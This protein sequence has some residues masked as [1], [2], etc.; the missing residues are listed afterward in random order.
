MATSLRVQR[1]RLSRKLNNPDIARITFYTF[2]YW[3]G[4]TLYHQT[5]DL[6]KV[7]HELGHKKIE[8]T[9]FYVQIAESLYDDKPENY[10]VATAK[11]SEE[12]DKLLSE[13]WKYVAKIDFNNETLYKFRKP[14]W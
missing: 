1:I 7:K 5:K 3:Y 10:Y 4:T 13:G 8:N 6:L 12:F 9:L 11:T 14:K 2:R